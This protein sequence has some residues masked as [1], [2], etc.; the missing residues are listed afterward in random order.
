MSPGLSLPSVKNG[1]TDGIVSPG[2]RQLVPHLTLPKYIHK[3]A[4]LIPSIPVYE[5]EYLRV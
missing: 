5:V 1:D 4:S 2:L 3:T